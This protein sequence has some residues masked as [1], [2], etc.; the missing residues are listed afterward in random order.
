MNTRDGDGSSS[1][2]R[3]PYRI[4]R[5][6]PKGFRDEFGGLI[7]TVAT[8]R[9]AAGKTSVAGELSDLV[10]TGAREWKNA[11]RA[12]LGA[13]GK[14]SV[15]PMNTLIQDVRYSL[16]MLVKTPVVSLIAAL[17]LALGIAATASML[18]M[19][20]GFLNSSIPYP[21]GDE[22]VSAWL[23]N[24]AGM[25]TGSPISP[26]TFDRIIEEDVG[27]AELSGF[28]MGA[29]SL[30]VGS[31]DPQLVQL[32]RA[33]GNL[34]EVFRTQPAIGRGFT[35]D[36]VLEGAPGVVILIHSFWASRFQADPDLLG[37]T[38][39][40]DGEPHT[41]IGVMPEWFELIPANV[42][43]LKPFDFSTSIDLTGRTVLAMGRMKP[44]IDIGQLQPGLE[45][46]QVAA[47][48]TWPV[49]NAGWSIRA[50]YLSES[51]PGPTDT[52]LIEILLLVSLFGL[53]IAC[54]NVANLLLGRAEERQR[55]VAVRTA[56][57]AGRG[58]ILAQMLT[59]SV[60]LALIAGGVGTWAAT[61]VIKG[62]RAAMPPEL[63]QAM[64][65]TLTP[66]VLAV[67]LVVTL[68]TG[69]LFGLAPALHSVRGELRDSLAGARGGTA[70]RSRKRLRNAFVV[71]EFA[72]ALALLTGASVLMM[73]FNSL[74][75]GD[76]GFRS[77][78]IATFSVS[79]NAE[80]YPDAEARSRFHMALL[81]ELE[82]DP[83][84]ASG[85]AMLTLPRARNTAAT[86]YAFPGGVGEN[87]E[88]L[89]TGVYNIVSQGY[90]ATL[91]VPLIEGRFFEPSDEF[92]A[93]PVVVISQAVAA[94]YFPGESPVGQ[95][96]RLGREDVP[97][98]EN[99]G[100]RIIGVVADV[101]QDRLSVNTAP[102][103]VFYV[104]VRQVPTSTL[105]YAVAV[106]G[107]MSAAGEAIRAR[108]RSLDPTIPVG[109]LQTLVAH[110]D[111]QLSGPRSIAMFVGVMGAIS[112][113]L[114]AMGIYGVMAHSV[115][116]RTREI[117]IRMAM[118]AE[119]QSVVRLVASNGMGL[120]GVGL[121]V[122]GPLAFLMYLA[123]RSSMV[124]LFTQIN[125]W[126]AFTMVTL[127]LVAVA[128][129]ACLIPAMRA[130]TIT[131]LRAL[132]T[133]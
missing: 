86:T 55:E 68:G 80:R 95:S 122:G 74:A 3:W 56:L 17:S 109:N 40:L 128:G 19:A 6:Y 108:L 96:V 12:G 66:G 18:A 44:G 110:V 32:I 117:G 94:R 71:G 123:V 101:A 61:F 11:A 24:G 120:V 57:G 115:V 1:R 9:L 23:D 93:E 10:R 111:T 132:G 20:N 22:I 52:R 58:R 78:G 50:E 82:G 70:G 121:I 100:R 42:H 85:A 88:V 15:E 47:A 27:F 81:Q 25:G 28:A 104:P 125:P 41:V 59:E 5:L 113:L 105:S 79:L 7:A 29:A 106:T 14:G 64:H 112:L 46:V 99:V 133:D 119:R 48:E 37:K 76:G 102:R 43:L 60:V 33:E 91:D 89:P 130:S 4:V 30:T 62:F 21:E 92:E 35:E 8:E 49:S 114:A 54:A 83:L 87:A 2:P 126:P 13:A 65:P 39:D 84:F 31:G 118:G 103:A 73:A 98:Q 107:E 45:A 131:P 124:E 90:L 38:I 75:G 77:E 53:L 116:Q 72:V 127:S 36:D 129:I 51:F 34:L 67:V 97:E 69:I 63:P 16:R 26:W